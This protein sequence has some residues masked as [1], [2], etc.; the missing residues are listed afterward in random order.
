MGLFL[1]GLR[2][3]GFRKGYVIVLFDNVADLVD[4]P[5]HVFSKSRKEKNAKKNQQLESTK[6]SALLD[7][8]NNSPIVGL[9]AGSLLT[10][11]SSVAKKRSNRGKAVTPGSGEALLRGQVKT[12]LQK[13][14]EGVELSKISLETRPIFPHLQGFVS[15][16]MRLFLAPTPSNTPQVLNLSDGE[17]VKND[18]DSL[19]RSLNPDLELISQVCATRQYVL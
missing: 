15:S 12:L 9:A 19:T 13:V 8:T 10:P 7:I 4:D 16:P 6:H 1:F 14:E 5:E 3:W 2:Y 18:L 17:I 11:S